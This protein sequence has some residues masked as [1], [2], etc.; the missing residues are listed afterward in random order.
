MSRPEV[1]QNLLESFAR[2][3]FELAD[4][5]AREIQ[6]HFRTSLSVEDKSDGCLFDPVT[7]ADR[8]CEAAMRAL[9]GQRF[10]DHGVK[11]EEFADS[12]PDAE[13]VW[14]LDPIDGT[15]SFILGFTGWG[16]LIGLTQAGR[17]ILGMMHQPFTRE[18]FIGFGGQA[19]YEGTAG[20]HPLKVRPCPDL[21]HAMLTTTSPLLIED[22]DD[23]ARFEELER[24]VC[25]SRYGGDCYGYCMVADGHVDLVAETGLKMHDV[26]PLIPIIEGAGGIISGWEG[27]PIATGGR[28]LAAG[29]PRAHAAAL[30][31]LNG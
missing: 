28:V 25:M 24:K 31:I 30:E 14:V 12:N 19:S 21:A 16:T 1:S 5:A 27:E 10:P 29:D 3:A 9:I 18:T 13:L 4:A 15:K 8:A 20:K 23:R 26:A 7:A 11:G 6:P 2:F 17:P 22:R